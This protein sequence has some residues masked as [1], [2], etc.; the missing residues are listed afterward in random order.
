M[1]MEDVPAAQLCVVGSFAQTLCVPMETSFLPPGHFLLGTAGLMQNTNP[2]QL[3]L[4]NP[5]AHSCFVT[6]LTGPVGFLAGPRMQNTDLPNRRV[7]VPFGQVLPAGF[8]AQM[9]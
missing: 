7:R 9:L 5:A 8:L 6:G 1:T 3:I 4:I 2:F